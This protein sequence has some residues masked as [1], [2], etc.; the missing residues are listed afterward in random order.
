MIPVASPDAEKDFTDRAL[1]E[2]EVEA[3]R[4]VLAGM[5]AEEAASEMGV[6]ASTVGSFRQHAYRKLGVAGAR[7]LRERYLP[8]ALGGECLH[9]T[10]L[11]RSSRPRVEPDAS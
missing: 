1:T 5:T 6:G 7:E 8:A 10:I 4:S 3:A 11:P 2:R 9:E